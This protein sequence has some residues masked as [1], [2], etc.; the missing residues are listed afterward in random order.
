[1][2]TRP[3]HTSPLRYGDAGIRLVAAIVGAHIVTEYGGDQ[4]WLSR[5]FT[6]EYYIEF[7]S[8]LLITL[9]IIHMVY[10]V[11]VLLDRRYGW[12]EK[13]VQRV[14]LQLLFGI[15]VPT[16]VTFLLASL[17]F[18]IYGVNILETNYHIYALPFIVALITIFNIYYFIR[19]LLMMQNAASQ[20]LSN[21]RTELVLQRP[22]LP[23]PDEGKSV[24]IVQTPIKSLPVPMQDIAYFYRDRGHVYVRLFSG[25][26]HIV[27]Q[28]L[29]QI[30]GR[31]DSQFFFRVARHMIVN[32]RAIESYQPL[33]YGKLGLNLSPSYKEEV[34]V[35]KPLARA[36]K[37]WMDR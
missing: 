4:P 22:P 24:F 14:L 26:D 30:E 23:Q 31:L 15:I 33:A 7:G 27:S 34:N 6:K 37:R 36:F 19:Y 8:T 9:L 3:I 18:A 32:H 2:M 17:Y 1:M 10:L 35:S 29:E 28:S 12:L 5:L 20:M 21:G 11:T 25:S 13:P 16:L